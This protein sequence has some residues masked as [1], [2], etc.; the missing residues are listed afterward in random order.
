MP[1]DA[2]FVLGPF[3]VDAMGRL[4]LFDA[5]NGTAAIL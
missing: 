1:F 5:T 2:P 4:G 3:A